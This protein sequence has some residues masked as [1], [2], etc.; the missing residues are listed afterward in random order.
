MGFFNKKNKNIPE[1]QCPKCGTP[2]SGRPEKCQNCNLIFTWDTYD[3]NHNKG[4]AYNQKEI[5]RRFKEEKKERQQAGKK[6]E[7]ISSSAMNRNKYFFDL[8]TYQDMQ[9]TSNAYFSN[10][11][12]IET[13]WSVIYNLNCYNGDSADAF[14]K[15][16]YKNLDE[17]QQ[18]L[19]AKKNAKYSND[20]PPHVPAFVRLAMLYEKQNKYDKA[21]EICVRA[22]KCGAVNDGSK[23]QMYGRLARMIKKSGINVDN[24]TLKLTCS[25]Q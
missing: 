7:P 2:F 4:N 5:M 11:N 12:K 24:D 18:M 10:M 13:A 1:F 6:I 19:I 15:L 22:I 25:P 21:I 9:K 3:Q 23:G 20:I 8:K 14:E 16:C 17:L